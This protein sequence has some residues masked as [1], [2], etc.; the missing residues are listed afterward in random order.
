VC[1]R[2]R[3]RARVSHLVWSGEIITLY[4]YNEQV[5]ED[6]IRMKEQIATHNFADAMHVI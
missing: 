2:A 4:T 3:A 5:E 6:R 1:V